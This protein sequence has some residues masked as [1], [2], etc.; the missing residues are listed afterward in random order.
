M[1]IENFFPSVRS[2][3]VHSGW[4]YFFNFPENIADTLTSLTTYRGFLPQG[5]STSPGLANLVVYD[6]EPRVV[7]SLQERGLCY[8]RYVDD[9]IVSADRF[10][11]KNE[12]EFAFGQV[13]GMFAS[14]EL[15]PNRDKI[16]ISTPGEPRQVHSLNINAGRPTLPKQERSRIRAAV[17][18]CEDEEVSGREAEDFEELWRSTYGR[19]KMM[20]RMHPGEAEKYLQRLEVIEPL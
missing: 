7:E 1:D 15:S 20:E 8:S 2:T 18:Q 9:V 6:R 10:V 14:K 13:F 4:K 19:V 5:A 11:D 16:N 17:K 12:L 3:V